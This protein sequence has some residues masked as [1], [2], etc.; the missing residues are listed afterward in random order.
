MG[1]FDAE[2]VWIPDPIEKGMQ[3]NR[4]LAAVKYIASRDTDKVTR[5]GEL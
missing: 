2:E 5:N 1:Y 4:F 3:P